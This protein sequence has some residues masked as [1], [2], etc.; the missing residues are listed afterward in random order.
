M[1]PKTRLDQ[2]GQAKTCNLEELLCGS[3]VLFFVLFFVLYSIY[4]FF[5]LFFFFFLNVLD[6]RLFVLGRLL[7]EKSNFFCLYRRVISRESQTIIVPFVLLESCM[8]KLQIWMSR[9]LIQLVHFS[10]VKF[11]SSIVAIKSQTILYTFCNTPLRLLTKA[12]ASHL[13]LKSLYHEN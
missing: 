1:L 11:Y 7:V 3:F 10:S 13:P 6:S 9:V 5:M 2:D 12:L 4:L 8:D